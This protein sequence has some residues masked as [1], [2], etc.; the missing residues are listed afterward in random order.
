MRI[1]D[2]LTATLWPLAA[3]DDFA[4]WMEEGSAAAR[5]FLGAA[6][7]SIAAILIV[8]SMVP[9]FSLR[10]L[11]NSPIF[12]GQG[13]VVLILAGFLAGITILPSVVAH[14]IPVLTRLAVLAGLCVLAA[15]LG[16]EAW[17]LFLT[18]PL[19]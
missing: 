7:G 10:G 11:M 6:T 15:A 3:M 12:F 13:G 1:L 9:L 18:L 16:Y 19:R 5:L 2:R 14:V 17:R 4:N 8:Q